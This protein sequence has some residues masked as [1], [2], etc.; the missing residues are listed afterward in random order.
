MSELHLLNL[1]VYLPVSNTVNKNCNFLL[2]LPTLRPRET[3]N[4]LVCLFAYQYYALT[5]YPW[6]IVKNQ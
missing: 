4:I 2:E 3:L 5:K 6:F 1:I